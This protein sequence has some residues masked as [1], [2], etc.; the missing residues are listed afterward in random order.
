MPETM[1]FPI[2]ISCLVWAC[3]RANWFIDPTIVQH[4]TLQPSQ[5]REL[6]CV[7][8]L[9][10]AYDYDRSVSDRRTDPHWS[11]GG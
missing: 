4:F 6:E 8:V 9:K 2:L 1:K 7:G 10:V 3:D 5:F 11:V